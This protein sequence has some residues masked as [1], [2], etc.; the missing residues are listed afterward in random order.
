MAK[1][2][3]IANQK[4]GVG[5]TTTSVN[6]SSALAAMKK[7]VL[8]IDLDP[9]GNASSGLGIKR[10]EFQD[11]N[12][13]HVLIGEK[14]IEQTIQR[15]QNDYLHV[16]G[17]NPDLV[18]A[19]IELVDMPQREFRLKAA[20]SQVAPNYDFILIDCPPSLGLLTLNALT[21]ANSFLVPLQCEYYALE[22]LSQLLNTAGIIKKN[23]NPGLH[24][25]GIVLTMFDTRNNLSHQVVSE[26]KTHF[27]D[28][29]F[30]AII[31]RNVRLSEAPSHGLSIFGYDS[32]SPGAVKYQELA[33]E[34]VARNHSS[35]QEQR[36][37]QQK[38]EAINSVRYMEI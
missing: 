33:Q 19:E 26:I 8:L 38:P 7:R 9:Q 2:I 15:T 29:V 21:A 28:K 27:G 16:V 30:S 23:L 25:E 24:I 3:C 36:P 5:K 6:L 10:H 11:A 13:Y 37:A 4:G 31:P 32:K 17:A 22:G 1:T 34:L 18:G 35:A 20:I 14:T 12:S